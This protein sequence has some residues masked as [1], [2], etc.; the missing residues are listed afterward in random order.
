MGH[1]YHQEDPERYREPPGPRKNKLKGIAVSVMF[2]AAVFVIA[3]GIFKYQREVRVY[4]AV[5]FGFSLPMEDWGRQGPEEAVEEDR[6]GDTDKKIYSW[7]DEKGVTH[8]SNL[9]A[10]DNSDFT[11]EEEVSP[12]QKRTRII[13]DKNVIY[14][15]VEIRRG[16]KVATINMILDTGSNKTAVYADLAD[17]LGIRGIRESQMKLADGKSIV[18][19]LGVV[20]RIKVGSKYIN[21]KEIMII[22]RLV[23]DKRILGLLGQDF[24]GQFSY[25]I[26]TD[27]NVIIWD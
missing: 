13:I 26:D 2:A 19:Q 25:K 3:V 5:K 23:R 17:K 15:P 4:I 20:T 8:F 6:A 27:S 16:K 18:S 24:L 11:A 7:I 1:I 21:D 14:V 10:P 9:G 22:D 12:W